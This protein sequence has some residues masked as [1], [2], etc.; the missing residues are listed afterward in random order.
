MN[1]SMTVN[2]RRATLADLNELLHIAKST[3]VATYQKDN[4]ADNFNSYLAEAFTLDKIKSEL[5]NPDSEFYFAEWEGTAVGYL[6]VNKGEGQ[7]ENIGDKALEIERIY[8]ISRYQGAGIGYQLVKEALR[9][10]ADYN[11]SLLWLGV[12]EK[13]KKAIRFYE[14]VGF[15]AFDTHHF[16]VGDDLQTDILMKIE[17]G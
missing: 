16:N 11:L 15:K 7:T 17:L 2:M 9:I 14:R 5:L 13:N 10:A 4:K 3:F 12:W 6:K 1:K 8:V